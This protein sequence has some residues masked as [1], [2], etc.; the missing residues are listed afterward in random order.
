MTVLF[1]YTEIAD[2][3]IKC[4]ETLSKNNEVHIIRWPVNK[5]APFV[6]SFSEK[7]KVYDKN[8]F[9]FNHACN[10]HLF[11]IVHSTE[12]KQKKIFFSCLCSLIRYIN[13]ND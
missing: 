13:L 10:K 4:C 11:E 3:F 6:F 1:L 9:N 12:N 2:Y 5:E 7:L 8:K